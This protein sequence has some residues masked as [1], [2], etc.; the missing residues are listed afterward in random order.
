MK[1]LMGAI[2]LTFCVLAST[3]AEQNGK[4]EDLP[5]APGE[6]LKYKLK[7]KGIP[8]GYLQVMVRAMNDVDGEQTWHFLMIARTNSFADKIYKVRLL[9]N[10]Y[11]TSDLS[12]TL[13]YHAN[14]REGSSK[15]IQLFEYD[16]DRMEVHYQ[17]NNK[18]DRGWRPLVEDCVDPLAMF[19][20]LRKTKLVP[21][22][23]VSLW[24]SDGKQNTKAMASVHR[25]ERIEANGKTYDTVLLEPDTKDLQGVFKKSDDS[26]LQ[27]WVS[28]DED[29]VPV[30][31]ASEVTVG[32]FEAILVEHYKPKAN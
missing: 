30:K 32:S 7:W 29:H 27:L 8:V 19:Y 26:K 20:V 18:V 13:K 24:V 31:I 10:S 15:K 5:F 28:K 21:G 16:W 14:K 11:P 4:A 9:I 22:T 23:E 25:G 6:R 3:G 17:K 12:R 1:Q 2:L